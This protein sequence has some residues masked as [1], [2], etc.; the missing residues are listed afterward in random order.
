MAGPG[1]H[2]GNSSG[3]RLGLNI[4]SG[5][6]LDPTDHQR[7]LLR[8]AEQVTGLRE[9]GHRLGERIDRLARL[10]DGSKAG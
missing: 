1:R 5:S 3:D 8:L 10:I 9:S 6:R 2:K 4:G 7:L